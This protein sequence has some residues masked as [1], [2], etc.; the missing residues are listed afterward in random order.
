MKNGIFILILA[1]L[2]SLQLAQAASLKTLPR[3]EEGVDSDKE[4][5]VRYIPSMTTLPLAHCNAYVFDNENHQSPNH[6]DDG[7]YRNSALLFDRVIF[8]KFVSLFPKSIFKRPLPKVTIVFDEMNSSTGHRGYFSRRYPSERDLYVMIIDD[9]LAGTPGFSVMAAHELQ[10]LFNYYFSV[11]SG[12]DHFQDDW[13]NEGLSEFMEYYVSGAL[14]D[15][16]LGFSAASGQTASI[17]NWP[18][19]STG[20]DYADAFLWV[21]YLYWHF[22]GDELLWRLISDPRVGMESV[23]GN[24]QELKEKFPAIGESLLTEKS[25]LA[26]YS[27]ALTLNSRLIGTNHLLSLTGENIVAGL[28]QFKMQP[29]FTLFRPVLGNLTATIPLASKQS[30]YLRMSDPD[31]CLKLNTGAGVYAYLVETASVN[32]RIQRIHADQATCPVLSD[33]LG[34][35]VVVINTSGESVT[36]E[37]LALK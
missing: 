27:L 33:P 1:V 8:P 30:V 22:G 23:L 14:P 34:R 9:K 24:I 25:L 20:K 19:H 37:L 16:S 18:D 35:I 13:L 2:G 36:A 29:Q 12:A 28:S 7:P 17:G 4:F 10:H 11:Q 32:T 3:F 6:V 31:A 21:S 5:P 26:N 15:T